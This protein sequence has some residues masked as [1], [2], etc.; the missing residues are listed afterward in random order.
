M[1]SIS[2]NL[3]WVDARCSSHP[4]WTAYNT[5][6]VLAMCLV[7]CASHQ[8]PCPHLSVYSFPRRMLHLCFLVLIIHATPPA[9]AIAD[10]RRRPPPPRYFFHRHLRECSRR[11]KGHP[12][13]APPGP[14]RARRRGATFSVTD[15]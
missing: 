2:T 8:P 5:A 11:E 14:D 7:F 15:I 1:I 12:L 4:R 6:L 3:W 9:I 13:R 10:F